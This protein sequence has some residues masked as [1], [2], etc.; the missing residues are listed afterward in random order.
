MWKAEDGVKWKGISS[1]FITFVRLKLQKSPK[2]KSESII[3]ITI[4]TTTITVIIIRESH[5]LTPKK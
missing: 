4:I 1:A 2:A 5:V 3:I